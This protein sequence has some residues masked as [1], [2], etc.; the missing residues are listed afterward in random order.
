MT[1]KIL[2]GDFDFLE[3]E[4]TDAGELAN[5]QL[6]NPTLLEYYRG[7]KD[8]KIVWNTVIDDSIIEVADYILR[9]N[10]EDQG[11]PIDMRKPIR[12]YINTDGG[13]L[14]PTMYVVDII[15]ASKTPVY[16]FGLGKAY[17]AGGL[18]LMSGHKRFIFKNTTCLIHDGAGESSG[19]IGKMLDNAKFT[20]ELEKKQKEY[21]LSMTKITAK[22]YD[23]Q[24]RRDWFMFSDEMLAL[25]IADEIV[26]DLDKIL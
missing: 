19:N 21:I 13:D 4:L 5:L 6:P 23:A 17:S 12:F 9:W 16:T 1:N 8:R 14:I 3:L 25:G 22:K 20:E 15:R 2:K 18:L 11:V 26:E 24:Y 7:L 10:R